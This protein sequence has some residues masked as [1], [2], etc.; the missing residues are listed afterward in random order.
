MRTVNIVNSTD[1]PR[2][3]KGCYGQAVKEI[4]KRRSRMRSRSLRVRR[5]KWKTERKLFTKAKTKALKVLSV[6][7]GS[8]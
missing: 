8:D 1:Q 5:K 4:T 6:S 3:E 7:T 2:N